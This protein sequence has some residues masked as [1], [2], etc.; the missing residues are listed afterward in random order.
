MLK[1]SIA[2]HQDNRRCRARM[3]R[4]QMFAETWTQASGE[5]VDAL[6]LNHNDA[7][8]MRELLRYEPTYFD[9]NKWRTEPE[10]WVPLWLH[11]LC[12][13]V[14]PCDN[15]RLSEFRVG[16][17]ATFIMG[18]LHYLLADEVRYKAFK[19]TIL[20]DQDF[21]DYVDEAVRDGYIVFEAPYLTGAG[22]VVLNAA[23]TIKA[24]LLSTS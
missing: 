16:W 4:E 13:R 20:L 3:L 9:E 5:V 11:H 8:Q 14:L 15:D 17:A 24:G 23:P 2:R 19:T 18:L 6:V 10:P 22:R 7:L 21:G 12:E 1:A